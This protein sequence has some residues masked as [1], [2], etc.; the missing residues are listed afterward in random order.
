[1]KWLA[2][3]VLAGVAH[4]A[5][6]QPPAGWMLDAELAPP[7]A[8]TR[9]GGATTKVSIYAYRAPVQGAV[10]YV[11]RAEA[12]VVAADRDELA[13]IE[14]EEPRNA[15]R[16]AG[17]GVK[18]EQDA[19]HFDDGAKQL[20]ANVRWRDANVMDHS[21]TIVAGDD[22]RLVAVS[23]QC[24]LALDAPVEIVKAC[25]AALATLDA[26]VPPASRVAL[27]IVVT[28]TEPPPKPAHDVLDDGGKVALPPIV[29]D[30]PKP[31][32]DRRPVYVGLGLVV[33]AAVF[34]WN[35]KRRERFEAEHPQAAPVKKRDEDA[36]DLHAA[37]EA[38]DSKDKP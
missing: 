8:A 6:I 30:P 7:P 26:E 31:E 2:L 18:T 22:K 20:E 21:R 27:S 11:N 25:D 19:Q 34:W 9:F 24:V 36:D 14:I 35:R 10:L 4:A 28:A 37:A 3:L 16:R 5:P 12:D 13:T 29:V 15:M 1:M 33:L 17:D 32:P 38:G 23:G